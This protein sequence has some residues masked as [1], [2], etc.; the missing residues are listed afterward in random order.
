MFN[1]GNELLGCYI[2]VCF[3]LQFC[4][5]A[6]HLFKDCNIATHIWKSL[7]VMNIIPYYNNV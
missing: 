1:K 4:G 6:E 7:I 5:S 2:T 3:S